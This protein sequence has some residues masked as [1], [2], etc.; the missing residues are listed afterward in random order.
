MFLIKEESLA[1]IQP[2]TPTYILACKAVASQTA[3]EKNKIKSI[4]VASFYVLHASFV[5]V[6]LLSKHIPLNKSPV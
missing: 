6:F 4:Y 5:F 1:K 2:K 3:A